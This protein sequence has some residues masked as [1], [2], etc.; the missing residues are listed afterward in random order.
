MLGTFFCVAN[1]TV[2]QR[3]NMPQTLPVG[4]L[5]DMHEAVWKCDQAEVNFLGQCLYVFFAERV[6]FS[7]LVRH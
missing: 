4:P 1:V 3:T 2:K 6:T 5:Y 7:L